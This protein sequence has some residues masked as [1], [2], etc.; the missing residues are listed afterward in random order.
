MH[1]PKLT[2]SAKLFVRRS[3]HDGGRDGL[4]KYANLPRHWQCA[5]S[6]AQLDAYPGPF[7]LAGPSRD[8][9]GALGA[10]AAGAGPARR[11]LDE[12]TLFCSVGLAGT[13][14]AVAVALLRSA[15]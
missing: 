5:L 6:P 3:R 7:F 11:S 1:S 10:A 4:Y 15:R 13:E 14:I 8:R 12:I 2:E 9:M